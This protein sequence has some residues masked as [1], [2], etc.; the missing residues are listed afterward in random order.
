M[1]LRQ[2]RP[3]ITLLVVLTT[4]TGVFYPVGM[5]LAARALF[6]R[7]STG[8][9]LIGDDGKVRGSLLIG[10]PFTAPRWFHGRPSATGTTPYDP[11]ASG[12]SNLGPTSAAFT[13]LVAERAAAVR[14]DNSADTGKI[15]VDL[16]TASASGLDPHISPRAAL[17]QVR[18]VAA[19]RGLAEEQVRRL[20]AARIEP[21]FLGILGRP[22]VNVLALNLALES[23]DNG[24]AKPTPSEEGN[25]P[26]S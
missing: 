15:P 4:I 16:V 20:V 17:L 22:R 25:R 26:S 23:L 11:T 2:L 14:R 9:L 10:Q 21:A 12:G 8:S 24:N 13:T 6:P 7:Q 19:A 18:R 1:I 3:A 5:T